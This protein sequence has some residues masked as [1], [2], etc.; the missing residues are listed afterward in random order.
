MAHSAEDGLFRERFAALFLDLALIHVVLTAAVEALARGGVYVPFEAAFASLAA[1]YATA[2]VA[3]TGTTAG[4]ALCG[5]EV[6]TREGA[7]VGPFRALVRE[8]L[9][10]L[11]SAAPLLAGF[12]GPA[13]GRSRRT[14]HDALAGTRV[15]RSDRRRGPARVAVGVS[16][17]ACGL[18]AVARGASLASLGAVAWS[19]RPPASGAPVGGAR[20]APVEVA[21]LGAA[22][23]ARL[24]AWLETHG[25]DPLDYAVER[26]LRHRVVI[27]GETH[28]RKEPLRFLN[29]LL[30]RLYDEA[31]VTCVALEA[32]LAEDDAAIAR[33]VNAPV[34]DPGLALRIARHHPSRAW[35][36]KGY[37]DVLETVWRLNRSLPPTAPRMRVV[38]LDLPIDLPSVALAGLGDGAVDGGPLERLRLVRALDQIPRLLLRDAFL[39]RRV[40][41]EILDSGERGIVWVGAAHSAIRCPAPG[42]PPAGPGRMGYLLHRKHGDSIFQ[43]LLHDADL[44]VTLSDPAYRGPA[45]AWAPFVERLVARSGGAPV[46][47]DVPGSPLEPLR[48]GGSWSWHFDPRLTLGDLA[49]GY[50]VLAPVDELTPCDWAAG[51]VTPAMFAADAP[52][53]RA[54]ARSLGEDVR[55]ARAADR[56]LPRLAAPRAP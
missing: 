35:G 8:T 9:G 30:P 7:R 40:E 45:P 13:L 32:C 25:E 36:W 28:W 16:L 27:F 22:D 26:A 21:S 6:R 4:K 14:W 38:G 3:W 49:A 33:L 31:G 43:V 19:M 50:A 47:F 20:T 17:S 37:W 34:Y 1:A 11:L 54:L 41:R 29:E 5:L 48:D 39:A 18:L 55:D 12:L 56:V 44:P 10:K 53:Y 23:E 15:V 42:P 24:H 2:C 51:Y 46:A 52:Y